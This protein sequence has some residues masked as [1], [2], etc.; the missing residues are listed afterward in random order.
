MPT[1]VLEAQR[2]R[3]VEKPF[4]EGESYRQ[5]VGRIEAFLADLVPV[6][7]DRQVLVIGHAATR[8]APDHLLTGA[9]LADLVNAPFAWHEGWSYQLRAVGTLSGE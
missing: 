7:E 6:Y 1:S 8:W 3:R 5:V 4:P 9:D 2:R